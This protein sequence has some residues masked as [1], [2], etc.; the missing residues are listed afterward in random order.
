MIDGADKESGLDCAPGSA[1][2]YSPGRAGAELGMWKGLRTR[3][4]VIQP[5]KGDGNR[6]SSWV[7]RAQ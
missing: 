6:K 3:A 2:F 4:V 1:S 5:P 7:L